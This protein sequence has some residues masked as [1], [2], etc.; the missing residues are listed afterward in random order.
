MKQTLA[1][2]VVLFT[3]CASQPAVAP[4]TVVVTA[5]NDADRGD[6]ARLQALT[7]KA[8]R[9]RGAFAQRVVSIDYFGSPTVGNIAPSVYQ[10][11]QTVFATFTIK[12]A[13][14]H[15]L[16][17]ESLRAKQTT[18]RLETLRDAA[19]VIAQRVRVTGS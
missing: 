15:V 9:N 10:P 13:D 6:A 2:F 5:A 19:E 12:D 16:H 17:R 3:M 14:G 7:E 11:Y 8:I 4:V 1:V 18:G